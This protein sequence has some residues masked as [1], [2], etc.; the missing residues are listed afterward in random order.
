MLDLKDLLGSR[1]SLKVK[2]MQEPICYSDRVKK[3]LKFVNK[4]L[5]S[6]SGLQYN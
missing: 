4:V 5:G 2:V 6:A 1:Q 3:W